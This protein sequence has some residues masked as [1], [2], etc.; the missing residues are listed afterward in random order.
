MIELGDKRRF[1]PSAY[2]AHLNER[3]RAR[4]GCPTE[5]T[6]ECVYINAEHR[7]CRMRFLVREGLW[8]HECFPLEAMA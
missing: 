1:V 4:Y 2:L 6:G 5:V 3:E 8:Q 7:F